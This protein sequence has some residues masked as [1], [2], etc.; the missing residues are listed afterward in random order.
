MRSKR[1]CDSQG[2]K[3]PFI[4]K[5]RK[6]VC[7]SFCDPRRRPPLTPPLRPR[8]EPSWLPAFELEDLLKQ[9]LREDSDFWA[10]VGFGDETP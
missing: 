6:P 4:V 1:S 10:G 3:E 5:P 8:P 7:R 2:Y 9:A